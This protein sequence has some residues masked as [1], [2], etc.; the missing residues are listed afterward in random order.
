M[1]IIN[2]TEFFLYFPFSQTKILIFMEN[3]K[4]FFREIDLFDFTSFFGL[5]FLKF[6][7]PLC[8]GI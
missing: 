4:K 7:G 3:I 2:F 6:S 8:V 5:D 1:K